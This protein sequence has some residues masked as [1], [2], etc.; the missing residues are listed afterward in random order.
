MAQIAYILLCHK[1]PAAIAAQVNQLTAGGDYVA[2]HFDARAGDK[3]FQAIKSA[4][5]GNENVAF[6]ERIKCGWGEWSLVQATLNAVRAAEAAFPRATHFYM[7]SG[8]C[9]PIKSAEYIHDFLDNHEIDFIESFD[10]FNSDWIKTGM[11]EERLIYRHYLNER[12]HKKLFYAALELQKRLGL[13]REIPK[14]LDI[15]VGSQWWCLRRQTIE[16]I[17]DFLKT[18]RDVVRFFRT[19]WIPDETF[20]QTLVRHLVPHAEIDPRTLTFLMFSDYG[21]PVTFY[22]D[23]YDLL[24]AQDFMFARKISPEARMLKSRLGA[25]YGS[26]QTEFPIAGEGRRLHAYLTQQGR[27]GRRFAPRFWEQGSTLGRERELLILVCKKWHVAKRLLHAITRATNL[28]GVE[29]LFDEADAALPHL[30]GIENAMEKRTRHR[31]AMMRMLFDYHETNRMVICLDPKNLELLH[32]FYSD[33]CTTRILEIEC[34]Y[35]EHYLIGHALRVGL[36]GQ[37]TPRQTLQQLVPT[38]RQEFAYEID[39]IRDAEF[40]HHYRISE[41]HSDTENAIPLSGFLD[42][43]ESIAGEIARTDHLFAE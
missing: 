28:T 7:V 20:F 26:G 33:R 42:I 34:D 30:G 35:S 22:N 6:A 24:V 8:D 13:K 3:A 15:M 37:N 39:A 11:R 12:N 4:L 18:R 36:A 32:D 29:F 10:Y 38:V 31:R 19:T 9:M 14:G 40:P 5:D 16:R 25:L 43:S 41:Q 1:D 27:Y 17:L 21:M 23:Q 2:V